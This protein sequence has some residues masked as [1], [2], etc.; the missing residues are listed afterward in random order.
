MSISTLSSHAGADAAN[1]G[2]ASP[3]V[4]ARAAILGAP[5]PLSAPSRLDVRARGSHAIRANRDRSRVHSRH[6][7]DHCGV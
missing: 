2:R 5:A 1:P 3:A 6:H 7:G 4:I